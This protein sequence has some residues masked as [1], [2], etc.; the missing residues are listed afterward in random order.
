MSEAKRVE[1]KV[2]QACQRGAKFVDR[3]FPANQSSV[4]LRG[5]SVEWKRI[6]DMIDGFELFVD[7][8]EAGDIQQGEL[9]DCWF[10]GAMS[11]VATRDDLLYPLVVSAHKLLGFYQFKFYKNGQWRVVSVDDFVPVRGSQLVFARCGDPTEVWVP[12]LEKAFA[13]L[14]GSYAAIE[15]GNFAGMFQF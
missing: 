9:G 8:V 14:N 11:V 6:S 7:G 1:A 5:K 3:E 12:L 2:L 4:G 13:K 15:S 10:L